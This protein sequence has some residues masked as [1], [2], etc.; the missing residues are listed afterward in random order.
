MHESHVAVPHSHS[1]SHSAH[2]RANHRL[3]GPLHATAVS[4]RGSP[5][6]VGSPSRV[7]PWLPFPTVPPPKSRPPCSRLRPACR[8]AAIGEAG[9]LGD[10]KDS[11][12]ERGHGEQQAVAGGA[13][14]ADALLQLGDLGAEL[15]CG[16]EA[17][18]SGRQGQRPCWGQQRVWG[19]NGVERNAL[20]G[21]CVG[22][23]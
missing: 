18:E 22:D 11:E 23:G 8:L 7:R 9:A 14:P 5:R 2:P 1:H 12:E 20:W 19:T 10:V 17:G 21:G 13:A 6:R 4:V 15:V 3:S 16:R